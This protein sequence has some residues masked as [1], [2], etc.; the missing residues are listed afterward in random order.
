MAVAMAVAVC[1]INIYK[2]S[3]TLL[4]PFVI[5]LKVGWFTLVVFVCQGSGSSL[6]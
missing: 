5:I 6:L 1:V 2:F 3:N 4:L